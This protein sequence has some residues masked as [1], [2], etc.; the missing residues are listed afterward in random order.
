[1]RTVWRLFFAFVLSPTLWVLLGWWIGTTYG[2]ARGM[3]AMFSMMQELREVQ[4]PPPRFE[5]G[6]I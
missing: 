1:M 3:T 4:P 2:T 6:E 5:K